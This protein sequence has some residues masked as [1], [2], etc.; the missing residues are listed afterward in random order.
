MDQKRNMVG[1]FEIPSTNFERAVRFYQSVF[2][3]KMAVQDL[4]ELKMAT[5]PS[6]EM[7]GA[8]GAVVYSEKFYKPSNDGILIYFTSPSGDLAN[9]E[10]RIVAAG[11]R[12]IIPKRQISEELGYMGLFED[13]EG[14]RIALHSGN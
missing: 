14:N 2:D 13:S 12:I 4:G 5:F 6:G 1:W 10:A 7:P 9:E 8:A 3:I 11:G